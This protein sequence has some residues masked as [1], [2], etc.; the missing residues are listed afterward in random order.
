[1]YNIIFKDQ[2]IFKGGDISDSK[3]NDIPD[4]EIK[5]IHYFFE[6]KKIVLSKFQSYN[7]LI[8]KVNFGAGTIP[9][10]ILLSTIALS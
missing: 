4:K 10:R 2:T 5:E 3:W 8:E 7:H 6:D 9:I 1:M